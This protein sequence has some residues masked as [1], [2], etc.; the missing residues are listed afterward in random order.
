MGL[1]SARHL[2]RRDWGRARKM[3]EG[4][5][6]SADIAKRFAI[7]SATIR[8][9]ARREGWTNAAGLDG[10]QEQPEPVSD[11]SFAHEDALSGGSCMS[12]KHPTDAQAQQTLRRFVR[13]KSKPEELEKLRNNLIVARVMSGMT[14][15]EAAERLGY[16]NSTQL[17]LIESGKRKIPDDRQFIVDAARVYAVSV[18]FLLGLSPHMEY[19]ARVARQHALMRGTESILGGI[20]AQFATVMIQFTQQTQ[21]VPEDFERVSAAAEK[22]EN[23]LTA[24]RERFGLDDIQGS[25]PL[26]RA[27]DELRKAV[28]PLR[29][30]VMRYRAID[31]YFD[32]LRSGKLQPIPYLTERY[33]PDGWFEEGVSA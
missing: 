15:V 26:V 17:S 14:A 25:A 8:R 9:M 27:A 32:E 22:V 2:T 12:R 21:P 29:Q 28:E 16:A 10:E 24:M 5:A 20:A 13:D 1:D 31:S 6:S 19:D 11:G 3:F 7:P 4:G 23:A 18:D 33:A 30:K